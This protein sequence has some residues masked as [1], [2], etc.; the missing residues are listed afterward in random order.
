MCYTVDRI[1]NC[2]IEQ[3]QS[4]NLPRFHILKVILIIKQSEKYFPVDFKYRIPIIGTTCSE[5]HK[6]QFL[7][8]ASQSREFTSEPLAVL[9]KQQF[10]H[11][12]VW[13]RLL[14]AQQLLK[15]IQ[16]SKQVQI[17][18]NM[19]SMT[20]REKLILIQTDV[21]LEVVGLLAPIEEL[22][23]IIEQPTSN[24]KPLVISRVFK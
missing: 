2:L 3:Q 20:E 19:S 16:N 21:G 11:F 15:Q 1:L 9:F 22:F 23:Y 17:I 5:Q 7:G 18:G 6:L 14:L 10:I 13:P 8:T 4:M 24:Q 12:L